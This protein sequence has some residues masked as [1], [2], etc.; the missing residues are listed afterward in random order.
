MNRLLLSFDIEEFDLPEEYGAVISD[1]DKFEISRKGTAAI[2]D[3]LSETGVCA[4]FFVT[5][6]FAQRYPELVRRMVENNHEI[7]SHGMNHSGFEVSHLPESKH[8][9]EEISGCEVTGFRM[10]RL[11]KVDKNE[12]KNAGYIY[13][14]SLNPI[15][16]PGHYCNLSSPLLPFKEN[17]GLWQFPVSAVPVVRFPLFWL[18]FKNLPLFAYK[19]AASAAVRMTGYYN[20]YSHPWEYNSRAKEKAWQIPGFVVRHAGVEQ[21]E[22][23]KKLIMT[24]SKKGDFITFSEYLR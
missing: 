8:I 1:E 7:A 2:L 23:L 18:A 17:C 19:L 6:V 22:R 20:M 9:L 4:T 15:W 11:A 3:V 16:L 13:E 10:A 14:S 12:L 5:A 24:L 21:Q